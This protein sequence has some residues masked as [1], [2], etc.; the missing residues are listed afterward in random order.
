VNAV[1]AGEPVFRLPLRRLGHGFGGGIARR[2]AFHSLL[3]QGLWSVFLAIAVVA[4]A[5]ALIRWA[6]RRR[7]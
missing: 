4:A 5:F 7:S 6:G 2:L 1:H 3:H